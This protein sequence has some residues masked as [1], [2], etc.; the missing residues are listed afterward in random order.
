MNEDNLILAA[1]EP[2]FEEA[3]KTRKWFYCSYQCLWF[4][5]S[6]LR[7]AHQEGRFIWSVENFTLRDPQEKLDYL[8]NEVRR[9]E[10]ALALF[11]HRVMI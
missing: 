10:A 7:A 4:S 1:F 2:M 8:L 9:A 11:R 6:E 5:P 3:K